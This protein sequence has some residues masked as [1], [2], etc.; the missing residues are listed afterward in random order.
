M[1]GYMLSVTSVTAFLFLIKSQLNSILLG[2]R[3]NFTRDPTTNTIA[4][5]TLR[6][7]TPV[8]ME[9]VMTMSDDTVS[10]LIN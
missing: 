5:A 7:L 1:P 2:F 3:L 10:H 4:G 9:R 6:Q 8:V